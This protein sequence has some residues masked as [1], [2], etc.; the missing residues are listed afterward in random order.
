MKK[1]AAAFG[2]LFLGACAKPYVGVPYAAPAEPVETIGLAADP[3][4]EQVVAFEA[5]STMS[6][7]GLIGALID[8]GVQASRKDRVNDALESIDY[9]P[10]P[11][12]EKYL[13]DAFA[14]QDMNVVLVEGPTREK[15]EFVADYPAAAGVEAYLDFNVVAFGYINSG[16]QMWRPMVSADVRMVDAATDETLMENRIVYNP[17]NPQAG[18]ITISPN[19]Q[20]VFQDREAMVSQPQMLAAGIDDALQQVADTAARLLK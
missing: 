19:P 15:R 2:L 4:P 11:A 16:N 13:V 8:A 6:N 1:C 5:A 12:F 18:V 7:F 14:K 20:Y 9:A 10:E 3:L 17:V